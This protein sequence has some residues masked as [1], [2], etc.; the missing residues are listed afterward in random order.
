[1]GL[2]TAAAFRVASAS[3]RFQGAW[4]IPVKAFG[5]SFSRLAYEA[6]GKRPSVRLGR[7]I[8]I[9]RHCGVPQS[10]PHSSGYAPIGL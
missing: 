2:F 7:I 10:T 4:L 5:D 1:M 3:F 9:L 8:L 6:V